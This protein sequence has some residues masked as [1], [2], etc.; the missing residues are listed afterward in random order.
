MSSQLCPPD[1]HAVLERANTARR[2][3]WDVLLA[4]AWALPK[5]NSSSV[6][7]LLDEAEDELKESKAVLQE[8]KEA[9]KAVPAPAVARGTLGDEDDKELQENAKEVGKVA[10]ELEE[11]KEQAKQCQKWLQIGH[12]VTLGLMVLCGFVLSLDAVR[13]AL[14]MAEDSH[15]LLALGT[16]AVSCQVAAQALGTSQRHLGDTAREHRDTTQRLRDRARRVATARDN[17]R[18]AAAARGD[19]ASAL[20]SLSEVTEWLRMLVAAVNEDLET[21]A[22]PGQEFSEAERKLKDILVALEKAS[23]RHSEGMAEELK[24][25]SKPLLKSLVYVVDALGKVAT[26]VAGPEGDVLLKGSQ[27]SLHDALELFT[28]NLKATLRLS[29]DTALGKTLAKARTTAGATRASVTS[30]ANAWKDSVTKVVEEWNKLV[31][32]A[33]ELLS[34]CKVAAAMGGTVDTKD[35]QEKVDRWTESVQNLVTETWRLPVA[36]DKEKAAAA[37]EEYRDEVGAAKDNTLV[38]LQAMEEAV[39]ATS[40]VKAATQAAERAAVALGPL[41]ALVTA[42]VKVIEMFQEL[43]CTVGD[44][45]ATLEGTKGEYPTKLALAEQLWRASEKLVNCHLNDI[46]GDIEELLPKGPGDPGGLSGHTVAEKCQEAIK[47]IPKLLP[48]Q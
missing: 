5:S 38:A 35:L 9:K 20:R 12:G 34:D 2:Q 16:V 1:L 33:T 25:L 28:E 19:I 48:R 31:R 7:D 8:L 36:T 44:I 11:Q 10:K 30:A 45:Q 39:V 6:S 37:L 21:E 27:G 26:T 43:S 32:K 23:G 18:V 4:L 3:T 24:E 46:I 47:D 15:L 29:A 40:Q 14:G 13:T 41:K 42:C 22:T 17:A